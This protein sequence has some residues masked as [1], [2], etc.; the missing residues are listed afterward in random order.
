MLNSQEKQKF[1]FESPETIKEAPKGERED[2]DELP[3]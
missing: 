2:A 1:I 3:S